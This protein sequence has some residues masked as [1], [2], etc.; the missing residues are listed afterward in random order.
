MRIG[1]LTGGGDAPGLN[2]AIRGITRKAVVEGIDVIG[3]R[4][5]WLGPL[6]SSWMPLN[7]QAVTG[8]LPRAG[9]ILGSSRTNPYSREGGTATVKECLAELGVDAMIPIGGED[10][11]GVAARLSEEGVKLVGV[12][13]TIDN[14]LY[15][16]EYSIG[17]DTAVEVVRDSLDK[18]HPTAE[19]HDRIMVVEVMGRHAGWLA[20]VGGLAGAAH[21]VLIPEQPFSLTE[22]LHRIKRRHEELGKMFSLIVA[23]EGAKCA[24]WGGEVT[25]SAQLDEFGHVRLGGIGHR[26]A[27]EIEARTGFETREV[28]LGHLQ[29]GGSPSAF[30]RVLATRLGVAAVTEVQAGNFG[31]MVGLRDGRIQTTRLTE[32]LGKMHELDMELYGLTELFY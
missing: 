7:I 19:A 22:L 32:I 11:L 13:K 15:G 27:V 4:H 8:I 1:V 28:V 29:R 9:T 20:T 30:D 12:P 2:A 24:D 16:T 18:L 3:F 10:T 5:G 17:F 14:D 23:S 21:A 31:V 26:L 25:S 6:T